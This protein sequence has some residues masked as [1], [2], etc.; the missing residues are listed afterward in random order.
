MEDTSTHKTSSF[1]LSFCVLI[2]YV[3]MYMLL[4]GTFFLLLA[5]L[6]LVVDVC[7]A[8]YQIKASRHH[9]QAHTLITRRRP[10]SIRPI[11][12]YSCSFSDG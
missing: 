11:N 3:F 6:G 4:L 7:A 1:F 2:F 10:L 12:F 8:G 9:S 5:C